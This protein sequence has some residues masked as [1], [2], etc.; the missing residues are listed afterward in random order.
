MFQPLR[1]T[2]RRAADAASCWAG[3][4]LQH[5]HVTRGRWSSSHLRLS[6]AWDRLRMRFKCYNTMSL[7]DF[8]D[9]LVEHRVCTVSWLHGP[10]PCS[11]AFWSRQKS[12]SFSLYSQSLP[13]KGKQYTKEAPKQM[14]L[15][16][17]LTFIFSRWDSGIWQDPDIRKTK[18][19]HS[20]KCGNYIHEAQKQNIYLICSASLLSFLL[21]TA[22]RKLWDN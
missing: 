17:A 12:S 19:L 5:T 22:K 2:R 3:A 7:K 14:T 9:L 21:S 8:L 11:S 1:G 10:G 16:L 4:A 20:L 6:T 18:Q 13:W 15:C